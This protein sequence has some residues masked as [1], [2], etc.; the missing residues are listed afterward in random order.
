MIFDDLIV[1]MGVSLETYIL[2]III[3][4]SIIFMAVDFRLG[5]I[6]MFILSSSFLLI[7]QTF[8]RNITYYIY[9]III[10]FILLT[11]SLIISNKKSGG[12]Y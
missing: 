7:L 8:N 3:L 6:M 4:G 9:T 12:G 2:L 1:N 10:S 5:I 11:L